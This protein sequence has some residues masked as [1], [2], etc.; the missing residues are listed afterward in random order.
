MASKKQLIYIMIHIYGIPNCGSVKKALDF[1]KTR[2]MEFTFHDF[3]KEGTTAS[4]LKSWSKITGWEILLN[5]KGTTWRGLSQG[6][7]AT[8][9][10][11]SGAIDLMCQNTS[12]IKRPVVEWT[13]GSITVGFDESLF[14]NKLG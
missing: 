1:L 9:S 7:Q 3:K 6:Q 8:A 10:N 14:A 4:K 5:K 12:V 13:D 11:L 2:E